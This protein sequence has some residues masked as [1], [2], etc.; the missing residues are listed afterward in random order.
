MFLEDLRRSARP[1]CFELECDSEQ[2]GV[3]TST[4]HAMESINGSVM[5]GRFYIKFKSATRLASLKTHQ[6][7]QIPFGVSGWSRTNVSFGGG[8][9]TRKGHRNVRAMPIFLLTA[10]QSVP[11]SAQ[12]QQ[13]SNGYRIGRLRNVEVEGMRSPTNG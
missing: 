11:F 5:S 3:V 1:H 12:R 4:F 8:I 10:C 2:G 6:S 13:G 7:S 9:T